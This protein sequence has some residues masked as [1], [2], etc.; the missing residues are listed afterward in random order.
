MAKEEVKDK[1]IKVGCKVR[2]ESFSKDK[3]I[4]IGPVIRSFVSPD[5]KC[6]ITVKHEGKYYS[7][8]TTKVEVLDENPAS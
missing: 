8:R 3:L 4:I 6:Y 5:K 7:K 2:F 1:E